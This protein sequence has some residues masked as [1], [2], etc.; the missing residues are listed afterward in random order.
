MSPAWGKHV[1]E[2]A[3]EVTQ[4]RPDYREPARADILATLSCAGCAASPALSQMGPA[5]PLLD[6][7]PE[8]WSWVAH[9]P[10]GP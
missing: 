3:P 7:N 9:V 2:E 5:H 8:R 10:L 1:P 6:L 4:S